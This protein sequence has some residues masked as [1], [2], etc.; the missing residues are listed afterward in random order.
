MTTLRAALYTRVS[1]VEQ[2][3][4]NHSLE[5]QTSSLVAHA[6]AQGWEITHQFSDPGWSGTVADRPG[7]NALI[8][9]VQAGLVDVVLVYRLDRL[10][11]K[12]S[13][14][15]RLIEDFTTAG[16][17]FKSVSEQMI[18]NTTPMGKVAF[19]VITAFAEWERDTFIQRSQSGTH[20]AIEKGLWPGGITPY[21]YRIEEKRLVIDE[22]AAEAVRMI[23][24][25]CSEE[26]LST[27]RISDRLTALGIPPHYRL[28]G[29]GVRGKSTVTHWRP[30][31][32][33]RILKNPV[34]K[35]LPE[36]GKRNARAGKPGSGIV[37]G[38]APV[39]VTPEDWERAQVTLKRN[40]LMAMRNAR[41]I[42][43]LK[44]LIKCG[45][46]GRTYIG[47]MNHTRHGGYYYACIGRTVRGGRPESECC[48]NPYVRGLDLD[49]HVRQGIRRILTVPDQAL[50]EH[51][52]QR[53]DLLIGQLAQVERAA[54]EAIAQ[55][56]RLLDLYLGGDL[57]KAV[58][59]ERQAGLDAR[60][61][62][63]QAELTTLKD[64][65][66]QQAAA[67]GRAR[68][69]LAL[70]ARLADRLDSLSDSEWQRLAHE[71]V[72]GIVIGP[73]G[74]AAINWAL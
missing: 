44:S 46:C 7:L 72:T 16:A 73:D 68:D 25:L 13:L 36:Y 33:L 6:A 50:A 42:Y 5:A 26:G 48:R 49:E 24:R 47:T 30:G 56:S 31:G 15:Y 34:Y 10:A 71:L 37:V 14:A 39:I 61:L 43:M 67:E 45:A 19:G 52:G 55:R 64:A 12:P 74:T 70:S 27:V 21:G 18:D 2:A 8:Q 66:R 60:L 28:D 35:G 65:A 11:R 58:Y 63:L 57:D 69:V 59:L 41:N 23:Y 32:V 29:R 38:T 17:A 22:P 20:K 54:E 40:S 3:D 53:P 51:Q 9:S 62:A 1:T 4:T